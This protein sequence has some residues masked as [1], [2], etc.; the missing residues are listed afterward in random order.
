MLDWPVYLNLLILVAVANAAPV[1]AYLLQGDRFSLPLDGGRTLSDGQPIFGA[2]KTVRGVLS[3]CAFTML[4]AELL[5]ISWAIGLVI[6]LSAMTGDLFSS[7]VKRRLRLPASA[8]IALLDQIPESLLPA[9]AVQSQL[10]LT[11]YEIIVV[12]GLF[13]VLNLALTRLLK[14]TLQRTSTG[15]EG[16]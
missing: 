8:S 11:F 3:S 4:C 16:M 6:G 1:I 5:G 15:D 7:F 2:S 12:V 10:H 14:A 13:T 9:L